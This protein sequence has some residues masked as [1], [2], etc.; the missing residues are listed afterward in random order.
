VAGFHDWTIDGVDLCMTR[1]VHDP[2]GAAYAGI[3]GVVDTDDAIQWGGR[4][5]CAGG[6]FRTPSGRGRFSVTEGRPAML[7]DGAFFVSTR[8]GKQ[9]TPW[10]SAPP[11]R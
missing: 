9:F 5:L 7:P 6:A 11:T 10:S 4:H 1:L 3:E 8:R 2:A